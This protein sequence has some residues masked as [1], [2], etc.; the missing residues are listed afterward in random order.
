MDKEDN[1]PRMIYEL[2][3]WTALWTLAWVVEVRNEW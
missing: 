2:I 3:T 1:E